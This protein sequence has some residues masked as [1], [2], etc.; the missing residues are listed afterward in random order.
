[1]AQPLVQQPGVLANMTKRT[2][3]VVQAAMKPATHWVYA[4]FLGVLIP[5][6]C[7]GF[8][9]E[10]ASAALPDGRVYELVSA[11]S[12]MAEVYI[13]MEPRVRNEDTTSPLPV[14]VASDGGSVVYV[15]ESGVSGGN[16]TV[17][18]GE[19]EQ[20]LATRTS[21]GWQTSVITPE[22]SEEG[23]AFQGS[24]M[25]CRWVF[26]RRRYSCR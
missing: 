13:P 7:F 23:T 18:P 4:A 11:S 24:R 21:A 5:A 19:G 25:T 2:Q 26:S 22:H 1:V 12:N 16:G 10:A 17:G 20:W 6:L 15:G 14:Q 8:A 9:A 3:V